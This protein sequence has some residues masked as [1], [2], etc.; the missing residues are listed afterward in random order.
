VKSFIRRLG[1]KIKSPVPY[2]AVA[3]QQYSGLGAPIPLHYHFLA[4]CPPQWADQFQVLAADL[5]PQVGGNCD[6]HPYDSSQNGAYYIAKTASHN[7]FHWIQ[8]D[9]NHLTYTGQHDL[10]SGTQESSY[11][12]K[13]AKGHLAP[14]TSLFDKHQVAEHS[15][16]ATLPT[17]LASSRGTTTLLIVVPACHP[18]LPRDGRMRVGNDALG[19]V[20]W[21]AK[22][23]DEFRVGLPSG[24]RVEPCRFRQRMCRW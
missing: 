5:W 20:P 17:M 22:T 2:I 3:E 16:F 4:S 21:L 13:H 1:Q 18:P 23:Q 11:V 10:Y 14:L 15:M 12:P 9:L 19:I 6:I 24:K 7:D 8:G